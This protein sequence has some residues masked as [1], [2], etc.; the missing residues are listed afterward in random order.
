[1]RLGFYCFTLYSS[2]SRFSCNCIISGARRIRLWDL[3]T[4]EAIIEVPLND[5]GWIRSISPNGRFIAFGAYDGL[6]LTTWDLE[7]GTE[8]GEPL[9]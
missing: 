5:P 7:A 8:I 9:S 2:I 1:M 4:G 6:V 3:R